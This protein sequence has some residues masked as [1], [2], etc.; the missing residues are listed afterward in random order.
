MDIKKILNQFKPQKDQLLMILHEVQNTQSDHCIHKE[1]I[2]AIAEYLNLTKSQ[3][4]GVV[5]YYSMFHT[6]PRGKHIITVCKSPV[7]HIKEA[8][9]IIG[10]LEK[11]LGIKMGETSADKNFTLEHAECL[12]RCD[13]AP[14]MSINKE[15]Y[16]YLTTHRIDD[17]LSQFEEKKT[18]DKEPKRTKGLKGFFG[19]KTNKHARK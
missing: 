1:D 17:I 15:F 3:V 13:E 14:V 11:K 5:N 16:G 6:E 12:G 7:C 19:I 10:H 9:S 4:Y 18:T 8:D 2:A